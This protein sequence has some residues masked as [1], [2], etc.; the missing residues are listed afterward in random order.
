MKPSTLEPELRPQFV[1][2]A[3]GKPKT[4]KLSPE[5]YIKLLIEANITDP[6]L[7]PPGTEH[8]AAILARI[9]QIEK[10]CIAR[11]GHFDWE[12][13][14]RKLQDEYDGLRID[15]DKLHETGPAMDWEEYKAR[16]EELE[17]EL[18]NTAHSKSAPRHVTLARRHP[19]AR[20]GRHR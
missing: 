11:H 2:K 5:A 18:S 12:K 17:R 14:S 16:R 4:V 10:R 20:S 8:G 15:C 13:L 6:A 3:N 19:S 7:W 1:K 9:R